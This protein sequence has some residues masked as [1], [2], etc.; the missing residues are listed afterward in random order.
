MSDKFTLQTAKTAC[1]ELYAPRLKSKRSVAC[2]IELNEATTE[3]ELRKALSSSVRFLLI[4]TEKKAIRLGEMIKKDLEFT[5]DELSIKNAPSKSKMDVAL[6]K[7]KKAKVPKYV[8]PKY[9]AP[10]AETDE[11]AE[12]LE[13]IETEMSEVE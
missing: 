2:L 13:E 11:V 3:K 6:A 5:S 10:K 1:Q 9:V 4:N 8:A 7:E 12:E